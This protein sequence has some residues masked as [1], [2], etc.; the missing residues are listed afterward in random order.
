MSH[1]CLFFRFDTLYNSGD[2]QLL[3][4]KHGENICLISAEN[5]DNWKYLPG[6][7]IK[8]IK[9]K[10]KQLELGKNISELESK[11]SS[12]D[13]NGNN[14]SFPKEDLFQCEID[15][16][17]YKNDI[18]MERKSGRYHNRNGGNKIMRFTHFLAIQITNPLLIELCRKLRKDF[19]SKSSLLRSSLTSVEK[20]HVT[21]NVV[22]IY[23]PELMDEMMVVINN[24]NLFLHSYLFDKTKN[25]AD[26]FDDKRFDSRFLQVL[27]CFDFVARF[28]S[29][30]DQIS[31]R[32]EDSNEGEKGKFVLKLKGL[33]TFN[34]KVIF[35]DFSR[36]SRFKDKGIE[37][38]SN[39]KN[40]DKSKSKNNSKQTGSKK[41]ENVAKKAK[42]RLK[43]GTSTK[44]DTSV[45][46]N[47][48]TVVG[49]EEKRIVEPINLYLS[50]ICELI[51]IMCVECDIPSTVGSHALPDLSSIDVDGN[52]AE[53]KEKEDAEK[54]FLFE[55]KP[56]CTIAKLSKLSSKE[57]RALIKYNKKSDAKF[58]V[59]DSI[60]ASV[61]N[62][63]RMEWL[64]KEIV[65]K[66]E[67]S[68]KKQKKATK[69]K[70]ESKESE[71][72][73]HDYFDQQLSEIGLCVLYGKSD[74]DG[75]YEQFC[76]FN[77]APFQ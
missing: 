7:V 36:S 22:S 23:K 44:T 69:T 67:R 21:L 66:H 57:K 72:A 68:V 13:N 11:I 45:N 65:E 55:F 59:Q 49:K 27:K 63:E 43:A 53:K 25:L 42:W 75:Y 16:K 41:N 3:I 64:M 29:C 8:L 39:S 32:S 51:D 28:R 61:F 35:L 62:N 73:L 74:N 77:V 30:L 19:M 58:A 10:A 46:K 24:C 33:N 47:K 60:V 12:F 1:V 26:I 54:R 18:L 76:S 37:N 9:L 38:T 71:M 50:L 34:S 4:E 48:S 52:E 70:E 56:H 40:K 17:R 15:L 20:L 31:D 5:R 2:T 6:F 14:I